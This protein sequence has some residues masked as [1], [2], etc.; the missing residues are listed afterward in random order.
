MIANDSHVSEKKLLLRVDGVAIAGEV[1]S[2]PGG[3]TPHPALCLCHG[4]PSPNP[5][6]SDEGYAPLARR[7]ALEGFVA[8]TF[9][10]R[11]TGRS[12][13]NLDLL[14]WTR[15]L[16]AVVESLLET[17]GV[18]PSKIFLMGFSAG[19]AAAIYVAAHDGRISAVVS[20]AS[21]AE[22]CSLRLDELLEQCRRLGTIKDELFSFSSEEW[23]NHFFEINPIRWIGKVAPRPSLIL[24]GTDDELINIDHAERLHRAAKDPKKLVVLPGAGHRLRVSD[25]AM[26][27]AMAWLKALC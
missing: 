21:P 10:F 25:A 9:N 12:G 18:D 23:R 3:R 19:A 17:D 20:C 1:F 8:C 13:G 16:N 27:A 2:P 24:H 5:S 26:D 4:I 6:P 22:F 15:D 14:D 11:G 7:F